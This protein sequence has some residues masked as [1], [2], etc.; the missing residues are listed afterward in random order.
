MNALIALG[1]TLALLQSPPSPQSNDQQQTQSGGGVQ[2]SQ[3]KFR[4]VRS[5]SGSEGI[6]Q[7]GTYVIRDPRTVF[8]LPQDHRVIVY[9]EWEG[10]PGLHHFE[11]IWKGPGGRST[12]ISDFDYEAKERRFGAY[13]EMTISESIPTGLWSLEARVDAEVTGTHSFQIVTGAAP[14]STEPARTVYTSAE[15]Y[16]RALAASV[17]I[18]SLNGQGVH[19]STGSG[20]FF[21]KGLVLTAFQVVDGASSLRVTLPDG[22]AIE[23][24]EILAWN[25][26]QDWAILRIDASVTPELVFA[27]PKSWV[28]GDN[29]Y[30]LDVAGPGN[31]II[32]GVSLVGQTAIPGA[33]ERLNISSPPSHQAIGGP[34]LNEFGEVIGILG[35]SLLPGASVLQGVHYGLRLN[36]L[37]SARGYSGVMAT[38]SNLVSVPNPDT[39][40]TSLEDLL[41]TGQFL[42]PLVSSD[43]VIFGTLARDIRHDNGV[44]VAVDD[45][46]EFSR[47]EGQAAVFLNLSPKMKR[48]GTSALAVYDLDNKLIGQTGSSKIEL[49]TGKLSFFAGHLDISNLTPGIY[50]LDVLISGSPLWRTFFRITD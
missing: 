25:R 7:G 29:C 8:Y 37:S 45:K 27:K 47:R 3:P 15:I 43:D 38:P 34:L 36:S 39:H 23:S 5:I 20:F 17:S 31:R 41:R 6:Q 48:K 24:R 9:F 44:P 22:Q 2:A 12:S 11:G 30:L 42:A 50:R 14:I 1:V 19:S 21:S 35:G 26:R 49:Q 28:V 16:K 10:P 13:W 46:S 33:G 32:A 18:E 40:A 4:V